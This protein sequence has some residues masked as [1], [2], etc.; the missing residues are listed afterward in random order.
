MTELATR[1]AAGL[2]A[3][4]SIAVVA[5][6]S[7]SLSTSGAVAATCVGSA[8]VAA[9][10]LWGALLVAYFVASVLLSRLGAAVK[11]SRVSSIVAKGGRRDATQ[12]LANGGVF[13]LLALASLLAPLHAAIAAAAALGALASATADTW[14]TE[15]GTLAPGAPLSLRTFQRVPPGTSGG[16]SLRGSLALVAGAAFIALAARALLLS[17][18]TLAITIGGAAGAFADSMLGE[19]LQERRWC[20]SCERPTERR[21]HLCGSSTVVAGGVRGFDNDAVNFAATV[22]GAAVAAAILLAAMR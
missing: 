2:V 9:G 22:V 6:R 13:A 1:V 7:H 21:V 4:A 3:A 11:E 8:A 15:I 10:W 19:S 20:P 12:V 14:A 17:P 18:A 5:R 16:V